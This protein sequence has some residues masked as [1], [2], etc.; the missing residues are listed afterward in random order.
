MTPQSY[1]SVIAM[2]FKAR[3]SIAFA[4]IV[5][6]FDVAFQMVDTR[7]KSLT[8]D[9]EDIAIIDRDHVRVAMGWLPSKGRKQPWHL[10]I[11][12]GCAPSEDLSKIEMSSY[13][14]VA[15]RILDRTHEFLP[16][17][18]VLRGEAS[19]PVG[20]ALIDTLFE[21][22]HAD[23]AGGAKASAKADAHDDADEAEDE[24]RSQKEHNYA[25]IV[26][27][28]VPPWVRNKDEPDAFSKEIF[29]KAEEEM[30]KRNQIFRLSQ[31]ECSQPMRL[32]IHTFA[33]SMCLYVPPLGA[34]LFTYTMMRDIFPVAANA[35]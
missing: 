31:S 11:A 34:A 14:F 9:C 23:T 13:E 19:Q 28:M 27:T 26:D 20:P 16:S 32:T 4:D 24:I 5:D 18:A 1:G 7:T 15:D 8:W 17:T 29:D 3:P 10:V 6:E 21:L 35:I 22:L 2:E 30:I 25:E 33:L 12:V